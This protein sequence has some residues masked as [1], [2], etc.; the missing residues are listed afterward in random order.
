MSGNSN[1]WRWAAVLAVAVALV[2]PAPAQAEAREQQADQHARTKALLDQYLAHAGP[3]AAV[4]A[5]DG[6]GTWNLSSG[7]ASASTARPIQ[8]T[9]HFRVGSQTKTFTAAVVLQLVDEGLVDL[10]APIERYLPGVVAGNGYDGNVITVRQI[11]RHTSGIAS[12]LGAVRANPDGTYALAELVRA[13]LANPPQF[14]PGTSYGYSNVNYYLAGM[15]IE[16]L[17]GQ[18]ARTVITNRIIHPLGLAE[19]TFPAPGDRSLATPYLPGYE[20]G[21]LGPLFFWYEKTFSLEMS[22][23]STAGAITSTQPDL[24]AFERALADGKV[25]SDQALAQMR[26]TVVVPQAPRLRYGLGLTHIAL[27]CGGEAWGHGGDI[28]TGHTSLTMVTDDGRFASLVT[29]AMVSNDTTPTR[30][31]VIDAALCETGAAE[32]RG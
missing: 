31:D 13:G 8:P 3:G 2:A 10:D 7:S 21:R 22:Q 14:A 6:S 26:Q 1:R 11:L 12:T 4:Y 29:N 9:D 27:S 20:G 24:V 32:Q 30:Y 17:T 28:P 25:V 5:G 18:D 23:Y 16:R 19:T 15:L